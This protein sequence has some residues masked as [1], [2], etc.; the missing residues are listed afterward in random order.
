MS[1]VGCC[2]SRIVPRQK[3]EEREFKFLLVARALFALGKHIIQN[4]G[5]AT[6]FCGEDSAR[7]Q[8]DP[9]GCPGTRHP[10]CKK[11]PR[12]RSRLSS[13][14]VNEI[15]EFLVALIRLA[16]RA[17]LDELATSFIGAGLE[18]RQ[19]PLCEANVVPRRFP[20][21]LIRF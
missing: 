14:L 3:M 17:V 16:G 8:G 1:S 13:G 19:A 18:N 15:P 12:A 9:R 10:S 21:H 2:L 5:C 4:I 6:S 7:G 20:G 11:L